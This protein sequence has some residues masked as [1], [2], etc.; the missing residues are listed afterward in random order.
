MPPRSRLSARRSL[1][2]RSPGRRL[3]AHRSGPAVRVRRAD[4]TATA[5]SLLVACALLASL[6]VAPAHAAAPGCG[7]G[8]GDVTDPCAAAPPTDAGSAPAAP[9]R[10]RTTLGNPIELITGNKYQRETDFEAMGSALGFHRHYN[11]A[12]GDHDTGL[13]HGWSNTFSTTLFRAGGTDDEPAGL[14]ILQGNGRRLHFRNV[15]VD[16]DGRRV[17]RTATPS[18]GRIRW[19]ADGASPSTWHLSDGRTLAFQ[20][21]W[22]VRV[23]HPGERFLTLYYR[24]RQLASVTDETGRTLA[25]EWTPRRGGLGDYAED[26]LRS[27]PGHLAAVVL[28]DGDRVEYRYDRDGNLAQASPSPTAPRGAT[29]TRTRSTPTT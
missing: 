2:R 18:D 13:G 23:D 24:K 3:P 10:P 12:N 20:G 16:A 21:S 27:V 15:R 8:T 5:S 25:L 14:E 22:L 7:D 9:H 11:S 6:A 19:R 17:Y 4:R 29:T 28:P 26:G 1:A